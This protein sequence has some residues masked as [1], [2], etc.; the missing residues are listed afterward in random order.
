MNKDY[1]KNQFQIWE[2]NPHL[3]NSN[4]KFSTKKEIMEILSVFRLKFKF[5]LTEEPANTGHS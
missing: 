1:G 2:A 4:V 3:L 5:I